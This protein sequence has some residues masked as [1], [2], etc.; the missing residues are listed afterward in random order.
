M[1]YIKPIK[2]NSHSNHLSP[3]ESV[4]R[5]KSAPTELYPAGPDIVRNSNLSSMTSF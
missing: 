5:T 1:K 3:P 4:T 2:A